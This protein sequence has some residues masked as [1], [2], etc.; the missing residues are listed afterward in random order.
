LDAETNVEWVTMR[1]LALDVGKRR[2][3]VAISDPLG[4]TARPLSTLVRNRETPL[5]ILKIVQEFHIELLVIGLP[6]HM[7]GTEGE[8]ADDVR[9]FAGKISSA[10]CQVPIQFVDERL[11]SV[12]AEARLSDRRGGWRKKK[13]RV[14]AFAAAIIL[15]AYLN[16]Q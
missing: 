4:V 9:K 6:L 1:I 11:T 12:E 13:S 8:Q 3:G 15:E 7:N 10:G 14:D 2:I 16:E 5:Q